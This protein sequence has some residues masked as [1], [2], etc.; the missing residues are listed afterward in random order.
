MSHPT[1]PIPHD[2]IVRITTVYG[3]TRELPA[4]EVNWTLVTD[5]SIVK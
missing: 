5:W 3:D 2:V 1:H 4:G